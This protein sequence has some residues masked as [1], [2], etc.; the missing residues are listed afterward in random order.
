MFAAE[1][2][3]KK[4]EQKTIVHNVLNETIKVVVITKKY[5]SGTTISIDPRQSKEIFFLKNFI[6]IS[7]HKKPL[8]GEIIIFDRAYEKV[9]VTRDCLEPLENQRIVIMPPS[10]LDQ[11][12]WCITS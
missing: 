12:P 10:P 9:I 5:P 1:K 6:T 11:K 7:P 2:S 4:S 3:H 8:E